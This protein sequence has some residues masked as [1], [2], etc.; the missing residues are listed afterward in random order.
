MTFP[1]WEI[2]IVDDGSQ[3]N[4]ANVISNY[5]SDKRIHYYRQDNAGVSRARNAGVERSGGKYLIFLDSDDELAEGFLT[6]AYEGI[7]SAG[8]GECFCFST[9]FKRPGKEDNLL[10]PAKLSA[11]YGNKTG[12][13]LAGTFV[14]RKDAYLK[15][16]GYDAGLAFGE[17]DELGQRICKQ[18][19]IVCFDSVSLISHRVTKKEKNTRYKRETMAKTLSHYLD[20]YREELERL[21]RPRL[22]SINN[23][24]A[25]CYFVMKEDRRATKLLISTI[26]NYINLKSIKILTRILLFPGLYRK[27]LNDKG[28]V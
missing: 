19:E 22:I 10:K 6:R 11:L 17:N 28:L 4:S 5:Q 7:S 13:F 27:F 25:V 8:R 9:V 23:R 15:T 14:I 26:K 20:V 18:C 2:I 1:S 21:D 16:G 12:L 24:L 3:D